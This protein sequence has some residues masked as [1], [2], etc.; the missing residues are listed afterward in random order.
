M[1]IPVVNRF[2]KRI[3]RGC[4]LASQTPARADVLSVCVSRCDVCM[5]GCGPIGVLIHALVATLIRESG[6]GTAR[7]IRYAIFTVVLHISAELLASF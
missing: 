6:T 5:A 2:S 1:L 3:M 7:L 4:L